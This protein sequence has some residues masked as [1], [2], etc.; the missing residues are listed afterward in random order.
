[1]AR[2]VAS[3]SC[4]G[5]G[6]RAKRRVKPSFYAKRLS[7]FKLF[8]PTGLRM[9]H[10]M[11]TSQGV[12]PNSNTYT[13]SLRSSPNAEQLEVLGVKGLSPVAHVEG[14]AAPDILRRRSLDPHGRPRTSATGQWVDEERQG[15]TGP[16]RMEYDDIQVHGSETSVK[17]WFLRFVGECL[18]KLLGFGGQ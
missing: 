9:P 2:H 4:S 17:P 12:S 16:R 15:Q 8:V 7:L 5:T 6:S 13:Q 11:M 14:R 10:Y 3:P 1:M 18:S